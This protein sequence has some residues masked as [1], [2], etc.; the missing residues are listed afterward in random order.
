MANTQPKATRRTVL[1][2]AGNYRLESS[3]R[4]LIGIE[5]RLTKSR[6]VLSTEA[7]LDTSSTLQWLTFLLLQL[8][9]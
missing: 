2:I 3:Y 1:K 5:L 6:E 9:I 8:E 4:M 7:I